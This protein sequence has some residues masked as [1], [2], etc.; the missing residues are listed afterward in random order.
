M[1][2]IRP[3]TPEVIAARIDLRVAQLR[4]L[5]ARTAVEY[6]R[7]RTARRLKML[8]IPERPGRGRRDGDRV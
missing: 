4:V 7:E 5:A 2:T 8:G 1:K 3:L 6:W